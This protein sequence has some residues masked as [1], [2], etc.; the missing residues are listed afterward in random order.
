[1]KFNEIEKEIVVKISRL[2][3]KHL[4]WLSEKIS[5]I[6]F[7]VFSWS[8]LGLYFLF[9]GFEILAIQLV[10]VFLIHVI[11]CEG[12]LKY[13]AKYL[14]LERKRPYLAYPNL[15]KRIGSNFSDHTTSFP[16]GHMAGMIGGS[17]MVYVAL[18]QSLP[19]LILA[20][21]AVGLSRIHNGLHYLG[22]ILAGTILGFI[23]GFAAL[24]VYPYLTDFMTF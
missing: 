1:M 17:F 5:D 15:I 2:R 11:F 16:S 7:L 21:L 13:G 22:D 9:N 12:L 24:W 20:S 23:Y 10:F 18:P 8:L 4:D 14:S 6:K 3:E 19:F